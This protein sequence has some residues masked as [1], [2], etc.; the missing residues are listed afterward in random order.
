MYTV[1]GA[2]PGPF[3][4][5]GRRR[6]RNP[7]KDAEPQSACAQVLR[8]ARTAAAKLARFSYQLVLL[9]SEFASFLDQP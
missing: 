2:H 6:R 5:A 4:V 7:R 3:R 8:S 9:G 1:S